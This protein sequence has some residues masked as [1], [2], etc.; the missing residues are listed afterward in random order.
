[1]Q[2]Q[3]TTLHPSLAQPSFILRLERSGSRFEAERLHFIRACGSR[4]PA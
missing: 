2:S 4:R 1:M 3:Q